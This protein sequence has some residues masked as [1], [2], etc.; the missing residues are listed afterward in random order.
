MSEIANEKVDWIR[1]LV[2]IFLQWKAIVVI[3]CAICPR[4]GYDT[5][6]LILLDQ[7]ASRHQNSQSWWRC[8]QLVLNFLR[9]DALYFVKGAERNKIYEQEWAFSGSYSGLLRFVGQCE[10]LSSVL[11]EIVNS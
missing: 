8:E 3:L 9:W 10:G 1:R 6:G 7:S 5:S 11:K 4:P 2:V